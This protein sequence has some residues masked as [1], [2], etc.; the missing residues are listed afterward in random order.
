[1]VVQTALPPMIRAL[2]Q[3]EAYPHPTLDR[4]L[5]ETHI[6]WVILAGPFAYKLRKPVNLGFVDF[7]SA[8]A[9]LEDCANEVRLNRRLSSDLYLGIVPVHDHDGRY[10]IGTP[11]QPDDLSQAT[12]PGEPAVLMRR[13]PAEGMLPAMLAR[14][15]VTPEHAVVARDRLRVRRAGHE[16]AGVRLDPLRGRPW[17]PREQHVRVDR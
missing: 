5:H 11:F 1:M 9:R 10:W 4:Q 16:D 14:D 2:L 7:T 3:P 17:V 6:S 8:A 13:L 15:A 12:C